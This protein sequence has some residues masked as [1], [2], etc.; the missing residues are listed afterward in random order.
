MKRFIPLFLAL[1][2]LPFI[3]S[4]CS[5]RKTTTRFQQAYGLLNSAPDSALSLLGEIDKFSLSEKDLAVYSLLYTM[6]QDKSGLDV[7]SDS[8]I[9][10]A[11]HYF[12]G[13]EQDSLYAK[14]Q[15]Y[16]GKYYLLNDSTR[17]AEE[18]LTQAIRASKEK[19]D[20]YIT[21][22]ALD[23]L[24]KS[25]NRSN[26][27]M[28]VRYAKEAYQIYQDKFSNNF[29]N[30]VFLLMSIGNS[31]TLGNEMD[32]AHVYLRKALHLAEE[33][34]N[35]ELISGAYQSF[36]G[37]MQE[38]EKNDS[39]LFF[40]KIAWERA[41]KKSISL[42]SNLAYAY[43]MADSVSQSMEL[44]TQLCQAKSSI[45]RQTAYKLLTECS[46]RVGN[47]QKAWE[48]TDSTYSIYRKRYDSMLMD[49]ASYFQANIQK[50][51]SIEAMKREKE[52][53]R[54]ILV[55]VCIGFVLILFIIVSIHRNR[56]LSQINATINL[57]KEKE[58]QALKYRSEKEKQELCLKQKEDQIILLK[59]YVSSLVDL[60]TI[61]K[62]S[63]EKEKRNFLLNDTLWEDI[64]EYLNALG[65]GFV[66]RL[67]NE[68]P[69]LTID[70]LRF[71]MLLRLGFATKKLAPLYGIAENSFKQKQNKFKLKFGLTDSSISLR[72]YLQSY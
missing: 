34:K 70:E 46:F 65:N 11:H 36:S 60:Q 42:A 62:D 33:S 71:C 8:L 58:M 6:A 7:D 32:S 44:L 49:K 30:Q 52:K 13:R 53:Q 16:M 12:K 19:G 26:P 66:T 61:I 40:A 27:K 55:G 15:Y 3:W 28:A 54:L 63:M 39:A 17:L 21:Y 64:E 57:E 10:I 20:Y 31:L 45:T 24:S 2:V 4:S 38:Q 48:Y 18:C 47:L 25:L 9:G 67:K 5:S 72:K 68:H 14:C 35:E 50:L 37:F 29:S 69:S 51:L 1:L 23:R 59:K 56:V 22:L 41:P 43:L